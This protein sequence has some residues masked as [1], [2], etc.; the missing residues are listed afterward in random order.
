MCAIAR[1]DLRFVRLDN[2]VDRGGIDQ[3]FADEN[4][5]QRPHARC[6]RIELVVRMIVVVMVM[7]V[8]HHAIVEPKF[9]GGQG[10]EARTKACSDARK[11]VG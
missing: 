11:S 6:H 10:G 9:I 7:I 3:P 5:F 8:R 2:G 1:S 4:G